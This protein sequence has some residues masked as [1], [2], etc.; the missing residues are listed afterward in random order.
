MQKRYFLWMLLVPVVS[1]A[2]DQIMIHNETD[3]DVYAAIYSVPAVGGKV[4]RSSSVMR[5]AAGKTKSLDRP[6]RYIG[7]DRNLAFSIDSNHLKNEYLSSKLFNTALPWVNV[8]QTKGTDFYVAKEGKKLEGYN[9]ASWQLRGPSQAVSA[10]T[11]KAKAIGDAAI[12]A[13]TDNWLVQKTTASMAGIAI[14]V[15]DAFR[16]QSKKL[17]PSYWQSPHASKGASVRVGNHVSLGEAQARDNRMVKV[18]QAIEN[19]LGPVAYVPKIAVVCSGGGIRAMTLH[20]GW[21]T[22]AQKTGL[23]DTILWMSV[24]SGSTWSTASWMQHSL[25][26]KNLSPESHR[27]E[28]FK[29]T[30]NLVLEQ[31][32][33]DDIVQMSNMFMVAA[34]YEKP[35]T[36]VNLWGAMIG[37]RMMFGFGDNKQGQKLSAQASAVQ[38]GSYPIPVYTAVSGE[39]GKGE[40]YWYAFT[41]WEISLEPWKKGSDGISIPMW[42]LGREYKNGVSKGYSPEPSLGFCL[43]TFGSAF[44]ADFNVIYTQVK[45]DISNP[46]LQGIFKEVLKQVGEKRLTWAAVANFMKGVAKS[47]FKDEEQLMM[48][49]AGLAF[50]LPYPPVSGMRADRSPDIIIFMDGSAGIEGKGGN[51]TVVDFRAVEKYAR[52]KGLKYPKIRYDGITTKAVS[53][54]KDDQD[55]SVPTVIYM[56]WVKDEAVMAKIETPA[57]KEFAKLKTLDLKKCCSTNKGIVVAIGGYTYDESMLISQLM[58][59]NMRLSAADVIWR[60]IA[61]RANP[62]KKKK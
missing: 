60:E 49:D 1:Y 35:F 43:G 36:A 38:D 26:T 27:K 15:T 31:M 58:E 9:A 50:N 25:I 29:A 45:D 5:V 30:N 55:P 12:A 28:L 54:F 56:P 46:L 14:T 40:K 59:C 18:K 61:Q 48:V 6:E 34:A 22:G 23:L 32:T 62:Q 7:Y 21:L 57:F 8:G 2:A 51:T 52:S 19:K 11:K 37:N 10:V 41:P 13:I 53:V 20:M 42:G 3:H 33:K 39:E 47:P 44:A 24:L 17:Y 4:K 16:E